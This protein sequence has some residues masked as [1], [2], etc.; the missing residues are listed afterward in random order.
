[1]KSIEVAEFKELSK[2]S[3]IMLT[4]MSEVPSEIP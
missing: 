4:V 1:M 3:Q 2:T